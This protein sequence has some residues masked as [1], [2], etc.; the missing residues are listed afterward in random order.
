MPTWTGEN[1]NKLIDHLFLEAALLT[2]RLKFRKQTSLLRN[3]IKLL[4]TIIFM[5][6][7]PPRSPSIRK[8]NSVNQ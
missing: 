6:V 7:T 3:N 5:Y 1:R 8:F 4:I 2:L